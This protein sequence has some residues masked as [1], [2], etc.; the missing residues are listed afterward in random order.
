MG[1]RKSR[2]NKVVMKHFNLTTWKPK[3]IG[4]LRLF[5]EA[6]KE[7][8]RDHCFF[9]S[10]GIAFNVLLCLIPLSFLFLA[11]IGAYLFS[12]QEIL[13]HIREYLES[14]FP[15]LDPKIMENVLRIMQDR[16][17]VGILGLGGLA[18]TST[19][20]FSS[21]RTALNMVF[22]V[23]KGRGILRGKAVDLLMILLAGIFLFMSMIFSSVIHYFQGY[24]HRFPVP[25]GPLF[26]FLLKYL[27]PFF[28]TFCMFFLTYKIAPNKIIPSVLAF[29]AAFFISFL[30]EIAKHLFG[31]YV[32]HLGRFSIIYGSLGTLAVFFLWIYYSAII[33]LLGAEIAAL[34]EKEKK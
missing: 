25:V 30:W 24:Q 6:L 2:K 33:F 16:Q 29:K 15:S 8:D 21:L 12:E 27:I 18:W 4:Q 23:D 14:I 13:I 17:I 10:S 19:W 34:L 1:G 20:V 22:E 11:L 32:L 9:L 28:F 26:S 5:L 31:W 7:F 3:V